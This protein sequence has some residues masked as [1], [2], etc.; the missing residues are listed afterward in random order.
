MTATQQTARN[1]RNNPQRS[2]PVAPSYP[3][4]QTPPC[5]SL[6]TVS[7]QQSATARNTLRNK[8]ATARNG[9]KNEPRNSRNSPLRGG[10]TVAPPRAHP[11]PTRAN[12]PPGCAYA[13]P[14]GRSALT[15]TQEARP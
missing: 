15:T 4:L 8:P 5:N 3:L 2:P 9:F 7:P 1:S 13:P 10:E 11:K 14:P 12:S 6:A